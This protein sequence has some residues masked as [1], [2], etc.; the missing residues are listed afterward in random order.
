MKREQVLDRISELLSRFENAVY[1]KSK[2]SLYDINI[3]SEN[4]IIPILNI[5]YG[6]DLKNLN[7]RSTTQVAIDLYDAD[8][9]VAFQV[10]S[11]NANKKIYDTL[12]KLSKI[13]DDIH[14]EELYVF[15]LGKKSKSISASKI[16]TLSDEA[17]V[18]FAKKHIIDFADLF[19]KIKDSE[20]AQYE[21]IAQILESEFS[22]T[23]LLDS[24]QIKKIVNIITKI[25]RISMW[26]LLIIGFPVL[27]YFSN[28]IFNYNQ[29][30]DV[31]GLSPLYLYYRYETANLMFSILIL[32]GSFLGFSY[33]LKLYFLKI[34][35]AKA[36]HKILIL[37]SLFVTLTILIGT[38]HAVNYYGF[39]SDY[40]IS[41]KV[42]KHQQKRDIQMFTKSQE[43]V[44]DNIRVINLIQDSIRSISANDL[45]LT[46]E[47]YSF[48]SNKKCKYRYF[49][50]EE[51]ENIDIY[52]SYFK[53]NNSLRFVY[54]EPNN[55]EY[56][57][58]L[59]MPHIY[60]KKTIGKLNNELEEKLGDELANNFME[61]YDYF[62][63]FKNPL[64]RIQSTPKAGL[65]KAVTY[66]EYEY[67]YTLKDYKEKKN[68]ALKSGISYDLFIWDSLLTS[69]M[70]QPE[71]FEGMD[72]LSNSLT[73]I[74]SV[75]ILSIILILIR[76]IITIK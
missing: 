74:H 41:E 56:N 20:E 14:C 63:A 71:Y 4:L 62:K 12:T 31:Y 38:V 22:D 46:Y 54:R 32:I 44:K 11:N 3:H 19:A 69:V 36:L 10:T 66:L 16:K 35:Y 75:L 37:I 43:V 25:N 57:L 17:N 29:I 50:G 30:K 47:K 45:S 59:T 42:K 2:N 8:K 52:Y 58:F 65:L 27:L 60:G 1:I 68:E 26:I 48:A 64:K 15:I 21:K 67:Q 70:A 76:R 13:E 73:V 53:A 7:E 61:I 5:L 49:I 51:F 18:S 24:T 40:Q 34:N 55:K 23:K 72:F 6:Y 33:L 39:K 9:K 28:M